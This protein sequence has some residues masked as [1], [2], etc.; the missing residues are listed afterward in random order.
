M[1]PRLIKNA[2]LRLAK[3]YP[4]I[5]ITG[6]RQSGKTTLS[7][8][9]FSDYQY[10]NLEDLDT[11]QYA[12]EDP[13]GFLHSFDH[14]VILDEIQRAPDLPSYIQ[15]IVDDE[16]VPGRFILTGSQ[17]FEL[18]N[19]IN[20][21]LAGRTALLNLLP[22]SFAE[23]Y[24]QDQEIPLIE[25]VLYSGFYPRIFDKGLSP[26]ETLSFYV[27]TYIERDIRALAQLKNL[28]TFE[29]FLRLCA[30]NVGQLINYTRLANDC[31]IT[32]STVI[33]WLSLL[34]ASYI[35]FSLN[36]HFNNFRK[37]LTKSN[38]LYFYD[39]G[40]AAFL[41]GVSDQDFLKQH[42]M[43]GHLFE[44]MVVVEFLKNRYNQVK[45]NNLY[46]F[47]DHVGNEVDL[48]LDYGN[49]LVSIEIKLGKT[50]NQ[51]YFKGL[52]FYQKLSG[53]RNIARYIVYGGD[54][55]QERHGVKIF[56]YHQL[57]IL[58]EQLP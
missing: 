28:S 56:P 46:F 30:A 58:F 25:H 2:L 9:S 36:P 20:Q 41:L 29:L 43:K 19:T 12:I 35:I 33:T 27:N 4:V 15:G 40:L 52:D 55:Y 54:D 47:R 16:D 14:G 22:L 17:Q 7:K 39:V 8:A 31:G 34:E 53:A 10:A 18:S 42:P 5:T 45:N 44:N 13:R 21:S 6:P 48:L 32:H 11:R 3:Q 50:I 1:Y 26:T 37:R 24:P 23:L 38:K 49:D 57:Q 51:G